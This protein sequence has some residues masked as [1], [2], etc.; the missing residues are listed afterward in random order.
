LPVHSTAVVA[1]PVVSILLL[2]SL[3]RLSVSNLAYSGLLQSQLK[4]NSRKIAG[5][6]KF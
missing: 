1:D 6:E 4:S 3:I 2:I 5:T